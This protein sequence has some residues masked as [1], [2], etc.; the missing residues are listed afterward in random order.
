MRLILLKRFNGMCT[1]A[2]PNDSHC[3][4]SVKKATLIVLTLPLTLGNTDGTSVVENLIDLCHCS[5]ALV[6]YIA[7]SRHMFVGDF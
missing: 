5:N 7:I 3:I 1:C 6:G 4:F 2:R